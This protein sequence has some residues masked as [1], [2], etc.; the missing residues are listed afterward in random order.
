MILCEQVP[1]CEC[2]KHGR[3]CGEACLNRQ[4]YIECAPDLCCTLARTQSNQE[5][6]AYA[7]KPLEHNTT[8][9][10]EQKHAGASENVKSENDK[11]SKDSKKTE[12]DK[13]D[14]AESENDK[15]GS[16]ADVNE[17]SLVKS[18]KCKHKYCSNTR[19][20]RMDYTPIDI[21]H[22]ENKGWALRTLMAL[23]EGDFVGE[24][25]GEVITKDECARRVA[26]KAA[27]DNYNLYCA[28]LMGDLVVDAEHYGGYV[29]VWGGGV[30]DGLS[31]TCTSHA[32]LL[33]VCL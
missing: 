11:I 33:D 3:D 27:A 25:C 15:D 18:K 16:A 22:T 6:S 26:E 8:S 19:I 7:L 31:C 12:N 14:N 17:V 23:Q 2:H 30:S 29:S 5:A 13:S 4:L 32:V 1:V 28:T 10:L 20:Q 9:T 24:Y 21:F